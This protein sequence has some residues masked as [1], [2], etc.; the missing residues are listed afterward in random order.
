MKPSLRAIAALAL[1]SALAAQAWPWS[2][3]VFSLP[4]VDAGTA[5]AGNNSLL[6][7]WSSTD[8]YVTPATSVHVYFPPGLTV[9]S[10]INIS[11]C[12][13]VF[14]RNTKDVNG[15]WATTEVTVTSGA[16]IPSSN[17]AMVNLPAALYPGKFYIRFDSTSGFTMPSSTGTATVAL[18]D[19]SGNT[20]VSKGVYIRPT[21]TAATT[22]G[23]IT[24]T[25]KNTAGT[26]V[27]AAF[28][29]ASNYGSYLPA[30]IS[31]RRNWI[32]PMGTTVNAYTTATLSDGSYALSV[33]PGSY[34]VRV[35]AWN[36]KNGIANSVAQDFGTVTVA[37]GATVNKSTTT[38]GVLP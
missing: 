11:T 7:V 22:M 28:V 2:S 19:P 27:A 4:F 6:A 26:A 17:S 23:F 33:A 10:S 36:A 18:T 9:S 30:S 1:L 13:C 24:G 8:N 35:E 3:A 37:D 34:T 12:A 15:T 5:V 14:I 29:F 31:A 32:G 38:L 21:F 16:Y 20:T 25:V